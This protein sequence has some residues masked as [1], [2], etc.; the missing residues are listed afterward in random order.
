M[1]GVKTK[2][3]MSHNLWHR[4]EY[5]YQSIDERQKIKL[6]KYFW[7]DFTVKNAMIVQYLISMK[8]RMHFL[9]GFSNDNFQRVH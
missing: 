8:V 7:E 3:I 9:G 2:V 4:Y 1:Q 6:I 5:F